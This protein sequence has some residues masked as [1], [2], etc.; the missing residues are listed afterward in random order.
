MNTEIINNEM[1][2][3]EI[4]NVAEVMEACEAPEATDGKKIAGIVIGAVAV[5]VAALIYKNRKKF[6]SWQ[7]KR[8]E[9][10]GYVVYKPEDDTDEF[11]YESS[12]ENDEC[13]DVDSE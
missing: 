6:E 11:E 8:L 12:T 7:I 9:K 4:E 1:E 5:G 3:E 10:K 13:S 2:L